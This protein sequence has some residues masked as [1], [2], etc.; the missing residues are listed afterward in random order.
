MSANAKISN[1]ISKMD[2][3]ISEVSRGRCPRCGGTLYLDWGELKCLMC[4]R[5]AEPVPDF[6]KEQIIKHKSGPQKGR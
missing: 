3:E 1:E 4:S 6:I 5:E 2:F